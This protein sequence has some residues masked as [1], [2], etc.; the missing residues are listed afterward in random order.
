MA[1]RLSQ[2]K[3]IAFLLVPLFVCLLV[4]ESVVRLAGYDPLRSQTA[5]LSVTGYFWIADETL[6]FRNR[7]MGRYLNSKIK[8]EPLVTTD[9]LGYRN[10]VSPAPGQSGRCVIFVGDSTVFCGE[11]NDEETGPSEVAK[12]LCA[13]RVTVRV[14][15]TGVRGFN[16][17]QAKRMLVDS[18]TRFPGPGVVVYVYCDNDVVENL[19]PIVYY[20]LRTPTAWWDE[21]TGKVV[22]RGPG[23][24]IVPWG[25]SFETVTPPAPG[26]FKNIAKRG[27]VV[28][29]SA[30]LY[31][32][33]MSV[34]TLFARALGK[35]ARMIALEDGSIGPILSGMD[36]WKNQEVWA[37]QNHGEQILERLLKEMRALCANHG[38]EF[39]TTRFTTGG[40]GNADRWLAEV[41]RRA[42]VHFGGI[43]DQFK[44]DSRQ[45]RA[46]YAG[47]PAHDG[48][49]N[50]TG[51]RKFADS[52]G[53]AIQSIL[54]TQEPGQEYG[55]SK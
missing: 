5:T 40:D 51:T 12:W 7:P 13:K 53:P 46:A 54:V 19:N 16:T 9:A 41:C 3:K 37:R 21:T 25:Q 8:G 30:L 34:S 20:P 52:L 22:E 27:L 31:S 43:S 32:T 28:S 23:P 1:Q 35:K 48:H 45:Y 26:V 55:V 2:P 4:L 14:I 49:Y 29:H 39:I 11:V 17:V 47:I 50:T 42:G 6:G 44:G 38:Y 24:Q 36:E 33:V 18:L 15:N 10:G